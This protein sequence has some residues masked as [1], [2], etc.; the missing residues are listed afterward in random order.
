M[1]RCLKNAVCFQ[2]ISFLSVIPSFVA[3]FAMFSF[4]SF[5]KRLFLGRNNTSLLRIKIMSGL[6]TYFYDELPFCFFFA[7]DKRKIRNRQCQPETFLQQDRA[8]KSF[9][10]KKAYW[11][12]Q[13]KSDL[14]KFSKKKDNNKQW[15]MNG[16]RWTLS[17][18]SSC[19][20]YCVNL[21]HWI[22]YIILTST[23]IPS[24]R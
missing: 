24:T 19:I 16:E 4:R 10:N 20:V 15:T 3:F 2:N 6:R 12:N 13:T 23:R 1:Y 21:K 18:A 5:L 7:I 22:Y 17:T 11:V 9:P 14:I 8:E